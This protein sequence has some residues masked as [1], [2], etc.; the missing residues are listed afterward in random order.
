MNKFLDLAKARYTAKEYVP[1]IKLTQDQINYI[2]EAANY[3]PTAHGLQPARPILIESDEI[4][5]LVKD[6]FMPH[7]YAKLDN[8]S[9]IILIKGETDKF[10]TSNPTKNINER[11]V[12]RLKLSDEIAKRMSDGVM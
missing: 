11:R 4:R 3:A 7:N 8:A 10:F 6:G 2:M 5:V 12:D 1:N 9:A